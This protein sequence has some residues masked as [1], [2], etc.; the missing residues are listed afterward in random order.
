MKFG[1]VLFLLSGVSLL[2]QKV[3]PAL[4]AQAEDSIVYVYE[5][6]V[7][8][9]KSVR[10][11]VTH[12]TPWFLTASTSVLTHKNFHRVC[13]D[14]SEYKNQITNAVHPTLGTGVS[15]S[16]GHLN[17]GQKTYW[18][19]GAGFSSYKESFKTDS[20]VVSNEF[21][22]SNIS[23]GIG[24]WFFRKS[25]FFSLQVESQ[26]EYS[27]LINSSGATLD[28][29]KPEKVVSVTDAARESSSMVN[30]VLEIKMI[31]FNHKRVKLF[32]APHTKVNFTSVLKYKP[33]Y[34]ECRWVHG[35]G[36]GLLFGL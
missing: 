10:T 16:L 25:N 24:K 6:P 22:Y 14:F 29:L 15:V 13:E 12:Y 28:Y 27:S 17:K 19:A 34:Y 8:L 21:S 18:L 1:A 30:G 9:E 5:P 32:L 7:V 4:P 33:N 3:V 36:L 11:E 23:L 20:T 35:A 31:F 2:G 26:I